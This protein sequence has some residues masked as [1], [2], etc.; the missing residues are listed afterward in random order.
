[1]NVMGFARRTQRRHSAHAR[2]C[3]PQTIERSHRHQC[4]ALRCR[5]GRCDGTC[6]TRW[7]DAHCDHG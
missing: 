3:A 1:L 2:T 5:Y 6:P 4:L 7:R